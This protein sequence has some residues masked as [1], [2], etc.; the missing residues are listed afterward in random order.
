MLRVGFL[1][2]A[3]LCLLVPQAAMGQSDDPNRSALDKIRK[4]IAIEVGADGGP[5]FDFD[6]ESG[7]LPSA[8]RSE[9]A[10]PTITNNRSGTMFD[11]DDIGQFNP[12]PGDYSVD[13]NRFYLRLIL[14]RWRVKPFVELGHADV[15]NNS[16]EEST[17]NGSFGDGYSYFNL[18]RRGGIDFV[19]YWYGVETES[20]NFSPGAGFIVDVHPHVN[21]VARVRRTSYTIDYFKGI[22]AFGS[23]EQTVKIASQDLDVDSYSLQ[24]EFQGG[25][26]VFSAGPTFRH[27]PDGVD[28]DVSVIISGGVRF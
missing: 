19:G 2:V 23:P 16:D 24:L 12:S 15:N 4:W 20:E 3:T 14:N 10:N 26:I 18:L 21:I 5:D 27:S 1:M 7:A 25:P 8:V 28:S 6:I 11:V 9:G 13:D 22:E 17:A